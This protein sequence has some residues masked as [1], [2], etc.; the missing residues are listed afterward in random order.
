MSGKPC[1]H[2]GTSKQVSDGRA[3]SIK[4]HLQTQGPVNIHRGVCVFHTDNDNTAMYYV[5]EAMYCHHHLEKG[6]KLTIN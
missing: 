6:L 5:Q 2:A 4:G 1:G 3:Q